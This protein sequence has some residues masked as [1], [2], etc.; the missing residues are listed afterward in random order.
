MPSWVMLLTTWSDSV[1]V[2]HERLD[3]SLDAVY[4]R[5]PM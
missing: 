4:E 5:C 3:L 1:S 2:R